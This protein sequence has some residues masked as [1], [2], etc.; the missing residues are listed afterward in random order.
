VFGTAS[1][2]RQ[3]ESNIR[4]RVLAKA[5]ERANESLAAAREGSL[6]H[7]TPH[8]CRRTYASIRY[9]LGASPAD[10][11][12]ELGHTNPSLAL[13][14]Y[15][16]AMRISDE[17]KNHLRVLVEGAPEDARVNAGSTQGPETAGNEDRREVAETL[18]SRIS[19]E[20]TT[21]RKQPDTHADNCHA[22]GRGFES[23][24]PLEGKGPLRRAFLCSQ[25][26]V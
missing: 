7:L 6:P 9:A 16:Q 14:V 25:R 22:E 1:G 4:R 2:G 20:S 17:E 11:M 24:Q 19:R 15:A 18:K 13:T 5:L 8:S 12:A 3:S 21:R 23:H 26:P 10:V